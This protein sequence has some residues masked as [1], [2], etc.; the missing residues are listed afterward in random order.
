MSMSFYGVTRHHIS[1]YN[2]LQGHHCEKMKTYSVYKYLT[3]RARDQAPPL[4]KTVDSIMDYL[5]YIKPHVLH[6]IL[7]DKIFQVFFF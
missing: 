4:Y 1:E 2:I 6:M 7:L 5:L 3:I